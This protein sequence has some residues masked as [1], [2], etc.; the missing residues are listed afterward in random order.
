[1]HRPRPWTVDQGLAAALRELREERGL[2]REEVA[3]RAGIST[4]ALARIEL[5][6][7]SPAWVTVMQI[8]RA[9]GLSL[10]ALDD[11]MDR[12]KGYP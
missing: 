9:L 3:F 12:G 7:S 5:G 8:A 11:A 1:M 10:A 2:S 4:G 6:Q